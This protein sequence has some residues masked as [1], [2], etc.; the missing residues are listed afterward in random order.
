MKRIALGIAIFIG[1]LIGALSPVGEAQITVPNTFTAGTTI[2]S[3]AMN[4]NFDTI[5][6]EA[7]N[8]TG[9]TMT[10]T[11][12]TQAIAAASN[13][14]YNIGSIGTRYA[15]VYSVLGNFSGAVS[16]GA[17]SA[18]TSIA[19][20]GTQSVHQWIETG[21]TAD[22]TTWDMLVD[23]ETFSLRLVS[24]DYLSTSSIWQIQRTANTLD[25]MS[26]G[27]NAASLTAYT[28][29]GSFAGSVAG[30]YVN[31]TITPASATANNA[32]LWT[33]GTFTEY[34]SG[35]H[36]IVSG[37]RFDAP[38][39]TSGAATLTNAAT[40]SVTGAPSGT[41]TGG[42]YAL[43]VQ[44]GDTQL[45]RQLSGTAQPGF[46]AYNSANDATVADDATVEFDQKIYDVSAN[47]NS[48]TDTW[49]APVTGIYHLCAAVKQIGTISASPIYFS[50]VIVTSNRSYVI[51]AT[52]TSDREVYHGTVSG[53]VH[54]D[55]D[56]SDTAYVRV[57]H[58]GSYTTTVYGS[59]SPYETWFSGRLVP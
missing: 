5:E 33:G 30:I 43:L 53:C 36:S 10:G 21:V 57:E 48:T 47:F 23:A 41:V 35:T 26:W 18:A 40:V 19:T 59:S 55:M 27:G 17:L 46:F 6:A 39:I 49:T 14:T 50:A 11:L 12:T 44:A 4:A 8:R 51:G 25:S 45:A 28:F 3:S 42:N 13:N 15:N 24:D 16:T 58:G 37:A 22:N 54:A 34:S 20:T 1:F 7:L 52:T 31:P 29:A 9:G 38:T 2:S 32:I 56:A